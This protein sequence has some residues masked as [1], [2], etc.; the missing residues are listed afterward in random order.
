MTTTASSSTGLTNIHTS[1]HSESGESLQVL[2]PDISTGAIS[3]ADLIEDA[4]FYQDAAIGYQDAY[5]TLRIQQEELQHRYTQQAQLVEEASEALRAAEAESS[6]R[7]QEFVTLQQ[8]WEADI[9]HA[10][11]KAMSQYQLQLSSVKSSL[12]QE[13]PGVSALHPEAAGA[14]A[15]QLELSLAGQATLPS[16][17]TSHTR[18]GLCEEVFNIL[19]GTVNQCRGAAQYNSQDQAFSFHKQVRFEDNYQQSR[20]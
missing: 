18:S 19:P 16:V 4:K 17:G 10:I 9:Q 11:D 14:G 6:L 2:N 3:A 13:G 8:Q 1:Q 12:Q 5:E 7:H 20:T 15:I